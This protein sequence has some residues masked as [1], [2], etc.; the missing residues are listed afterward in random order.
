MYRD[1]APMVLAYITCTESSCEFRGSVA[2]GQIDAERYPAWSKVKA[3]LAAVPVKKQADW[4]IRTVERHLKFEA[5]SKWLSEG[6][7]TPGEVLSLAADIVGVDLLPDWTPGREVLALCAEWYLR[8]VG[9]KA[10]NIPHD[11]Q[12][13]TVEELHDWLE[14][15][16]PPGHIP[17]EIRSLFETDG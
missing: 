4:L 11:E 14:Q 5:G 2:V 13:S 1:R 3:A 12:P 17:A 16:W 7:D 10:L 6:F 8:D 9:R 15:D